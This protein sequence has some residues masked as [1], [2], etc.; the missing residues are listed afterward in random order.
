[1]N[2]EVIVF[3]LVALFWILRGIFRF[4]KWTAGRLKGGAAGVNAVRQAPPPSQAAPAAR[5]PPSR[6]APPP[7][8]RPMP[9]QPQAGGPAVAREATE[10]DFERQ[11]EELVASEP[12]G[13]GTP[14]RSSAKS[15]APSK[16]LFDSSDD[17]VRAIILREALGPPLSRRRPPAPP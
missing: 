5:T 14:L 6:P 16:R 2:Y 3:L 4:F 1:V 7:A 15:A 12:R 9:R 8:A 11:E 13:L 10:R 17:L